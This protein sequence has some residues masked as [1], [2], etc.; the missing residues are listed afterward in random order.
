MKFLKKF[1]I[2]S[3]LAVIIMSTYAIAGTTYK[4]TPLIM[5]DMMIMIP[6]KSVTTSGYTPPSD[7]L[8]HTTI[9][10]TSGKTIR[11]D[12]T[13]NGLVFEG[14]VGKI[15]LLEVYG[16]SC[17]HC[18]AAIPEYNKVQA[19]YPKDVVVI[20]LESYGTLDNAGLQQYVNDHQ[21]RYLTVAQE[22]T[23][24]MFS[25]IRTLTGYNRQA[26][27]YLMI[28]ARDGDNVYDNILADYPESTI[29]TI[30]QGLL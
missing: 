1:L 13:P 19:K 12:R 29:D 2:I 8:A 25:F 14:Y 27:P 30:I 26:V 6:Y 21:I 16:S 4:Y 15:V 22:N 3:Q 18:L 17:P 5:D 28:F 10:T 9:V 24:T 20:T 7:S 23:G 11:V